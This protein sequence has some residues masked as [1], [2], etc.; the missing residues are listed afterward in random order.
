MVGD[1]DRLAR[2]VD[3]CL[4][5]LLVLFQA[6]DDDTDE[7]PGQD[8][9]VRKMFF[10]LIK[11]L[12][13]SGRLD[14]EIETCCSTYPPIPRRHNPVVARELHA[15]G[16][17]FRVDDGDDGDERRVEQHLQH[18]GPAFPRTDNHQSFIHSNIP[19]FTVLHPCY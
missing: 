9:R 1:G 6:F 11:R 16:H 3:D 8:D 13:A 19:H 17:R 4:E 2:T 14:H 12:R 15:F 5:H 18:L 10:Q 7:L